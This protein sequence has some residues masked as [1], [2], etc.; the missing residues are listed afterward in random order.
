[1][2]A[3]L[4]KLG[5]FCKS[6]FFCFLKAKAYLENKNIKLVL[7]WGRFVFVFVVVDVFR[8]LN[9]GVVLC[10]TALDRRFF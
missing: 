1:M 10:W 4:R 7:E 9:L 2:A 6:C 5:S 3:I 8:N